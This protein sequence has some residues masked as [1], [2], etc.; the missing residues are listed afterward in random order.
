MGELVRIAPYGINGPSSSRFVYLETGR[1]DRPLGVRVKPIPYGESDVFKGTLS[2]LLKKIAIVTNLFVINPKIKY[3]QSVPETMSYL[4]FW[5]FVFR[6]RGGRVC[7]VYT[8][9]F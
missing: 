7:K 9:F 4:I 2:P 3:M 6:H 1:H 8:T 5:Q